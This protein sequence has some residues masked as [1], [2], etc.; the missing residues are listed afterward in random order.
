VDLRN[1]PPQRHLQSSEILFHLSLQ[2]IRSHLVQHVA[3]LVVR[4]GEE[5]RLIDTGGGLKG[6]EGIFAELSQVLP[7]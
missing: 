2:K 3:E 6:T 4:L 7:A 1:P 5:N